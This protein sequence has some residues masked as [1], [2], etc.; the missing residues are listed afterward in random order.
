[1]RIH[2]T[3]ESVEARQ[4]TWLAIFETLLSIAIYAFIAWR[5]ETYV[6]FVVA[7][8]FAPLF[9][10]RTKESTEWL[11]NKYLRAI[12]R[13][14]ALIDKVV[15][16]PAGSGN[17]TAF[18]RKIFLSFFSVFMI[19][20]LLVVALLLRFFSTGYWFVLRPLDAV[21]A[22][23]GNWMQQSL[24]VDTFYLPELIPGENFRGKQ[25]PSLDFQWLIY[26]IERIATRKSSGSSSEI[27]FEAMVAGPPIIFAYGFSLFYRIGFKATSV[28]YFP[29]VWV[30]SAGLNDGRPVY[31]RLSRICDG[32]MEEHRRGLSWA[33]LPVVIAVLMVKWWGD[34]LKSAVEKLAEDSWLKFLLPW[35]EQ[36]I[37]HGFWSGWIVAVG[38]EIVLT[39][40]LLYYADAAIARKGG[41]RPWP[42]RRVEVVASTL[43][44]LRSAVAVLLVCS[45]VA[46]ALFSVLDAPVLPMP[47]R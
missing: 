5:F 30:S 10:L 2:S 16:K 1:M 11:Q 6:H 45:G 31:E 43:I 23:P 29:L 26:L 22:I 42:E 18:Y 28:F 9:L 20:C 37:H 7:G 46:F 27:A 41:A 34:G 39:T 44:T 8:V 14:G 19:S 15:D 21:R 25:N 4:P 47:A 40:T 12:E 32:K 13:G 36:I 33:M 24:C 17:A 35:L 38:I 3:V